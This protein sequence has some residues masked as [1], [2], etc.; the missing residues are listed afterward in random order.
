MSG[1]VG[2][3]T[4]TSVTGNKSFCMHAHML[5][6]ETVRLRKTL[7]HHQTVQYA[8]P[9]VVTPGLPVHNKP[10]TSDPLGQRLECGANVGIH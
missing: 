10:S 3:S 1:L 8:Y 7:D 5:E 9:D 6:N 2:I 4:N